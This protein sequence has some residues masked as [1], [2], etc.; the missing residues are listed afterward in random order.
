[1]S[2]IATVFTV[3][4]AV[5]GLSSALAAAAATAALRRLHRQEPKATTVSVPACNFY[6]LNPN[7]QSNLATEAMRSQADMLDYNY[8]W[9]RSALGM[10]NRQNTISIPNGWTI[11]KDADLNILRVYRSKRKE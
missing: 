11:E 3:T 9:A 6:A 4:F 5:T 2:T 10:T 7:L 1:M 8:N